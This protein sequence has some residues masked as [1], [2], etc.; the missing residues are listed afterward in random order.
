MVSNVITKLRN[1]TTVQAYCYTAV[2]TAL[3][4]RSRNR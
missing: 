3:G 1:P 4:D 2:C